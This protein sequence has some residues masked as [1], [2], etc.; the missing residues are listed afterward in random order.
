MGF[1]FKCIFLPLFGKLKQLFDGDAEIFCQP[2]CEC[3]GGR[4]D[5]ILN[6][7]DRLTRNPDR[8]RNFLLRDVLDRPLNPQRI[9]QFSLT[10]RY[11]LKYTNRDIFSDNTAT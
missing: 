6:G 7:I 1:L 2:K 9:L 5:R 4:I 10:H 11:F 8:R 3:R